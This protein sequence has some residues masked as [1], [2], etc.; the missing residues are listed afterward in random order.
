[1]MQLLVIKE[2]IKQFYQKTSSYT[3]PFVK[4]LTAAIVFLLINQQLGFNPKL[5]NL[6]I[7]LILSTFCAFTPSV[8]LVLLAMVV[9][10]GHILAVSKV[11]AILVAIIFLIIYCFF[12]KF[13]PNF[14]YV[15]LAI[16]ILYFL[17]IPYCIPIL[18][19][20]I[21]TPISIVPVACGVSVY[22]LIRVIRD[23]T[24]ATLGASMEDILNLVRTVIDDWLK[25]PN[26]IFAIFVFCAVVIIT[27]IIRKQEFDYAFETSII[28]GAIV[29]VLG[30]LIGNIG[31]DIQVN[32]ISVILGTLGSAIIVYIVW[33]FRLTLDHT[34]IEKIQF[35]DDDYYYYVKAVP[36]I[37][38]TAPEK[39]IKKINEKKET[40]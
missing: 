39:N 19:G 14:G 3:N 38:V 33:F 34:A 23:L 25:N 8:V 13:T 12:A 17:K 27:Y 35:E 1:M 37:K 16:P 15:V 5:N 11:L 32:L 4:F 31:F 7:V 18:L 24:S 21:A 26:M 10:I 29:N 28:A 30:F 20:L 40:S 9:S 22:F 6:P 36:K 2:Q